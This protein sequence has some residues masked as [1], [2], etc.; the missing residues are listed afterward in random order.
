MLIPCI[1]LKSPFHYEG[2]I[3]YCEVT[4]HHSPFSRS[5]ISIIQLCTNLGPVAAHQLLL[6]HAVAIYDTMSTLYSI[7]KGV[8]WYKMCKNK[9]I[10]PLCDVRESASAS[11]ED[12]RV[13]GL[14]LMA[15]LQRE[16]SVGICLP[17]CPVGRHVGEAR[18]MSSEPGCQVQNRLK[19]R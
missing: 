17:T 18:E 6:L 8:L 13:A 1:F 4:K 15:Q 2:Y 12:I 11:N 14:K 7:G 9:E 19:G 5:S 3:L 16:A 10:G